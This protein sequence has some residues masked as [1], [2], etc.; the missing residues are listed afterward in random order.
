LIDNKLARKYF[1]NF[2]ENNKIN[3]KQSLHYLLNCTNL[4]HEEKFKLVFLLYSN[5]KK[6]ISS[7][8]LESIL[9]VNLRHKARFK[10]NIK[11]INDAYQKMSMDINIELEY[12]FEILIKVY[13]AN[14]E[15]FI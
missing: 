2:S 12:E 8:D 7:K 3:V 1:N 6:Y 10:E 14:M 13:K 11:K 9:R 15:L 5:D 4:H